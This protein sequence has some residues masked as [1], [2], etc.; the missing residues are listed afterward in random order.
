[1]PEALVA[2]LPEL[3]GTGFMH[4][5]GKLVLVDLDNNLV[6]GVLDR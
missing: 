4:A 1:L 5:G 6:V 2:K 3:S